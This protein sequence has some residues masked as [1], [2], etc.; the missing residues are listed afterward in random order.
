GDETTAVTDR[1]QLPAIAA[2]VVGGLF[3]AH[4]IGIFGIDL[5]LWPVL[6][7]AAGL[8][9]VW[10]QADEASRARRLGAVTGHPSQRLRR[11]GG[12]A[13][14]VE[15]DRGMAVGVV[16]VGDCP[17]EERLAAVV[18]AAGEAIVNA[19]KFAKVD[20]VDVFLEVDEGDVTVFVRDT[21]VGFDPASVPDDRRGVADS[22]VARM[23]RHG[24][25]AIVRSAPGEGTEVELH[26]SRV[27]S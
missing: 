17:M 3:L 21:G 18:R 2:L 13:A 6:V 20:H 11:A 10:R 12:A 16:T 7:V 27:A 4:E 14:E 5:G 19:A 8:G 9:L 1:V 26:L 25:S 24:G 23:A 15:A 22:V